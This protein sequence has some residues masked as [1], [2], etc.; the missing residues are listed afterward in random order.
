M[1]VCL[2]LRARPSKRR[3]GQAFRRA[4]GK[5]RASSSIDTA[6]SLPKLTK[7]VVDRRPPVVPTSKDG[8]SET[9]ELGKAL[10]S[11]KF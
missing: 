3:M 9:A 1:Y 11:G 6:S 4:S 2:R 5:I 7:S 10:E 8:I